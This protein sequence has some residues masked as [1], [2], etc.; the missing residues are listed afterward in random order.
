MQGNNGLWA[1]TFEKKFNS[2]YKITRL[3]SQ[4]WIL[5][6]AKNYNASCWVSEWTPVMRKRSQNHFRLHFTSKTPFIWYTRH[7]KYSRMRC[8]RTTENNNWQSDKKEV[9]TNNQGKKYN[10]M[11]HLKGQQFL[12]TKT[13]I[14]K[15]LWKSWVTN[16]T[17][18]I[19]ALLKFQAALAVFAIF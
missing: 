11:K 17:L 8:S 7:F 12:F 1:K 19:Q 14:E 3:T 18:Q 13:C 10:S 16:K 15:C 6:S 5:P 9:L 2:I 4:F